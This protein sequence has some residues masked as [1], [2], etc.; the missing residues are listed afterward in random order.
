MSNDQ[1]YHRFVYDCRKSFFI[2]IYTIRISSYR[3]RSLGF[4]IW[5][6]GIYLRFGFW[7]LE[8]INFFKIYLKHS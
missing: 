2:L 4:R 3:I 5:L 7:W 8:F 6:I 1:N